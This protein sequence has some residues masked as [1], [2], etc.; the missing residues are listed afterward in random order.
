MI[1]I[2]SATVTFPAGHIFALPDTYRDT[3]L[4]LDPTPTLP[5]GEAPRW[6]AENTGW[7]WGVHHQED[8]RVLLVP[9]TEVSYPVEDSTGAGF[10][11]SLDE[12]LMAANSVASDFEDEGLPVE[13][14]HAGFEV[15]GWDTD[16]DRFD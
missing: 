16:V 13:W 10:D 15:T 7:A 11:G 1:G 8:G 4:A 14:V 9:E 5:G 12:C 2:V 6:Y 3:A